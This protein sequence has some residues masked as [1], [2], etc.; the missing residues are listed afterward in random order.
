MED[1]Q[2]L[3]D[4]RARSLTDLEPTPFRDRVGTV[5]GDTSLL[6]GALTVRTARTLDP[7]ADI[8]AAAAR[9]AGV[10]LCYEGLELTRSIL[11]EQS[12]DAE[13]GGTEY[14]QDL[15]VAEVLVSQGFYQL[16]H[17]GVVT[18]AVA[19]V[20]QFGRTQTA[21]DELG[22]RH[23]EDP[24]EVDVLELAVNGGA[25]LVMDDLSDPV[26]ARSADIA[27]TLLEYPLPDPATGLAAA[28]DRLDALATETPVVRTSAA[29][30]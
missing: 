11:R 17:T 28:A 15:L 24:L 26:R 7:T 14:Y 3:R 29:D 27:R 1:V 13:T 10:Q 12:W 4:A 8:D 25:D 16:A 19:I 18:D 6:P 23:D 30:D 9:G 5:V 21:L 22:G 2:A 20:Q